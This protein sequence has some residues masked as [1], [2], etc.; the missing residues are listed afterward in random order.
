MENRKKLIIRLGV[1]LVGLLL[2]LTFFSNT[3]HN[4]DVA[5]VVVGFETGGI[6]TTT[7]RSHGILTIPET[8]TPLYAD[9]AGRIHFFVKD[10][11]LVHEDESLF[12]IHVDRSHIFDRIV[13]LRHQN[14]A[15]PWANQVENNREIERLQR[16]LATGDLIYHIEYATTGGVARFSLGMGDDNTQIVAG[17]EILRLGVRQGTDFML[18]AYFPESLLAVPD[19]G[20]RQTVRLHIPTL[21][22]EE[23]IPTEINR[24]T[25]V[26]GQLRLE[27]SVDVPD[28]SGG[29]RAEVIIEDMITPVGRM[30]PNYAIHEDERGEFILIAR[31]ESNTL[32]GY[33]YFAERVGITVTQRGDRS[34]SF[35]LSGEMNGPIIFQ[36]DRH[37]T[38]GDRVRIVG[39]R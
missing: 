19:I 32:L 5:G 25:A 23:G 2:L 14:S 6:I 39:E 13:H 4:L 16:L 20:H 38:D 21:N 29:E 9:Y 17:Q 33:S 35:N 30:L 37:I 24:I 11:D 27:F 34:T 31:R 7:H 10:G 15:L 1:I 28:A 26:E 36:S 3:I 18:T 12:E 22:T 8:H